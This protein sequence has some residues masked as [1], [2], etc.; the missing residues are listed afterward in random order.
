[1][2]TSSSFS[3]GAL[4]M[5][6]GFGGLMLTHGIPKLLRLLDGNLE[7]VG[8]PLGVGAL[9]SSILVIIGEVVAPLL[10]IIGFK[11]RLAAIPV[12]ITMLVAAF[13][14]HGADPLAKK[15]MALLYLTGYLAIGLMGAGKYSVSRK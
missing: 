4:I 14:I 15:E 3:L 10:I 7:I 11:V 12:I 5:R 9:L 2:T 6:L 13:M 8:D 1:M